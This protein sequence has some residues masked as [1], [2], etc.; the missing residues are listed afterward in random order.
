MSVLQNFSRITRLALI[1]RV[2][3]SY[4]IFITQKLDVTIKNKLHF[5]NQHLKVAMLIKKEK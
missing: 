3:N 5:L 2:S 4:I 1:Y